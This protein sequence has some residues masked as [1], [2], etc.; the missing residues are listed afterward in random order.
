MDPV[1]PDHYKAGAK[2][3][4]CGK[5]LDCIDFTQ[6]MGFL[7]GNAMKYIWRCGRKDD[8]M[9]DLKKAR[10]YLVHAIENHAPTGE[11][12]KEE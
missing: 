9:V 3:P 2:C 12:L 1:S 7:L 10:W 6:H 8:P 11:D 4:H 5:E